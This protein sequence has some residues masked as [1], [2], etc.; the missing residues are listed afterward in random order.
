MD[1]ELKIFGFILRNDTIEEIYTR[2]GLSKLIK[3]QYGEEGYKIIQMF[4][5]KRYIYFNV[6]GYLNPTRKGY[7]KYLDRWLNRG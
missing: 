7:D 3:E 1:M 5:K 2:K 4:W 6:Y